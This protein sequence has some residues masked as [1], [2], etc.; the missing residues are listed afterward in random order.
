MTTKKS[1]TMKQSIT[2]TTLLII[3][4]LGFACTQKN[5]SQKNGK[6]EAICTTDSAKPS[7]VTIPEP[8]QS[9]SI[10]KYSRLLN[11][12]YVN[13]EPTETANAWFLPFDLPDRSN[14]N[15]VTFVSGY[16]A[17]RSTR[18][19]GHKHSGIDIVPADP[20]N[21]L[22]VYAVAKGVVCFINQEAP[23]KN[24]HHKTQTQRWFG[25]LQLIHS[26]ERNFH[27][28]WRTSR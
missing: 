28:T 19:K 20:K 16:G 27:G 26:F 23:V 11:N 9:D 6:T 25:N 3:L 10:K 22:E 2:Y 5:T 15:N 12:L 13:V 1:P 4:V 17:Y 21:G 14:L 7:E 24:R 8:L 18:V